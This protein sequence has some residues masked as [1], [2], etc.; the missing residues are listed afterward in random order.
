MKNAKFKSD[1]RKN[2]VKQTKTFAVTLYPTTKFINN[3]D[4]EM[5]NSLQNQ[6][7]ADIAENL[8]QQ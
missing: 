6:R 7:I 1:L 8:V 5:I 4:I 3:I 2:N